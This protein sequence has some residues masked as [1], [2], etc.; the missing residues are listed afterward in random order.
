MVDDDE[1]DGAFPSYFEADKAARKAVD[2]KEYCQA[3]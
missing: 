3:R 1:L 2:S